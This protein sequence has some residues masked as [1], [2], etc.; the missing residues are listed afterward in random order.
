[1]EGVLD[2]A[3]G[4]GITAVEIR[5]DPASLEE[6]RVRSIAAKARDKGLLLSYGIKND[7]MAKADAELF[8]KGVRLASACGASCVLRIMAS[9]DAL[10]TE[11]KRGYSAADMEALKA[12]TETYGKIASKSGVLVA[13][14]HARE[15]LYSA[16]GFYGI[17]DLVQGVASR[18]V[19]LTFDPANATNKSL[20]KSPSTS[21]EVLKFV[22]EFGSRFHMVHYKTTRGGVVQPAIG[23]ADTDNATL[24]ERLSKVYHGVLCVEIPGS[25]SLNDTSASLRASVDYLKAEKLVKY[26]E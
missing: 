15:P 5:D 4:L 21:S 3:S 25:P 23:D 8:E 7:M 11:G 19:G 16:G 6:N 22:D 2:L 13:I 9:Q 24:F 17:S 10:K 14:E 20:C 26:F 12:T 1:L 18:T